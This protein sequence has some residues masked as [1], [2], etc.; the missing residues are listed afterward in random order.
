MYWFEPQGISTMYLYNDL[1]SHL[2]IWKDQNEPVDEHKH[3]LPKEKPQELDEVEDYK[4][5]IKIGNKKL[6]DISNKIKS[7]D[8][9]HEPRIRVNV[10]LKLLLVVLCIS[11]YQESIIIFNRK[12]EN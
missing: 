10:S 8:S 2:L 12:A 11:L 6:A 3:Q 1:I 7:L 4:R 5:E 9:I